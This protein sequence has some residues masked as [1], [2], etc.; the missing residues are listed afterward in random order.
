VCACVCVC[1]WMCVCMYVCTERYYMSKSVR[2]SEET[3]NDRSQHDKH[4]HTHTTIINTM[5]HSTFHMN[6]QLGVGN[7][8]REVCDRERCDHRERDKR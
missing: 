7:A 5:T 1:V 3:E 4:S 8:K 2:C 6:Q